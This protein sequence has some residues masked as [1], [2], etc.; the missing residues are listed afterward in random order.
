MDNYPTGVS[1]S[2]PFFCE[3]DDEP[4][5]FDPYGYDDGGHFDPTRTSRIYDAL[6]DAAYERSGDGDEVRRVGGRQGHRE[7]VREAR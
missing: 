2:I 1:G 6:V 4:E 5:E 7:G 3:P